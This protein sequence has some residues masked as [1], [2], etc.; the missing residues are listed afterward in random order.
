M[1]LVPCGGGGL[2]SGCAIAA[3]HLAPQLPRHRRRARGGRRR[4]A[5]VQQKKLVN[6]EVPDTIA[7]GA[8][9]TS[10]G[11]I[12]FPAGAALRERDADR[13][14]RGA[15]AGDVLAVGAHEDRGRAD[16]RAR[17]RRAVC[18]KSS[19]LRKTAGRRDP[20]RR[21]RR[22]SLG[23]GATDKNASTAA[24]TSVGAE[25]DVEARRHR[26]DRAGEE[27]QA[28]RPGDGAQA[29]DSPASRTRRR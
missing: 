22:P 14:R 10:L 8:R 1:L 2:L 21:K 9:T 11:S 7:D 5:L 4:D 18:T 29:D 20:I 13:H 24:P 15:A 27:H 19:N 26:R 25:R 17:L 23:G 28:Q 3:R 12:T 16:R 6:I